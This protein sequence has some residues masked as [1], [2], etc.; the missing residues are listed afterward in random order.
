M[1]RVSYGSLYPSLRRLERDGAITSEP[2]TGARRKTVYAITDG[3]RAAVPRAA[4]GAPA[5]RQTEDARFRV[6]LAF[7]RYLPPETRIRL[8]ERRRQALE[9]RLADVKTHLRDPATADDYQRALLEHAR[10]GDRVRYRVAHRADPQRTAEVRDHRP[11]GRAASRSAR[12]CAG[13]SAHDELR[14]ASRSWGSATAP[15]PW[16]KVWSTTRMPTRTSRSP[17]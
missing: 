12:R 11:R 1:W 8:L 14:F 5:R 2:G 10:A 15:R 17:A 9:T 6:R 7:F 16:S 4:A 3:G 13:R